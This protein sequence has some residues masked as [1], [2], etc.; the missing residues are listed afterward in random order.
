[1]LLSDQQTM[2]CTQSSYSDTY[3]GAAYA[4]LDSSTDSLTARQLD[5]PRQTS[6]DLDRPRRPGAWSQARQ[7]RQALDRNLTGTRQARQARPRQHL[8]STSTV[9]RQRLDS[10]STEPRQ[11]D[12]STARAQLCTV[13][14]R[15]AGRQACAEILTSWPARRPFR[16][17]RALFLPALS[18]AAR[19]AP[20][21]A[22]TSR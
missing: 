14:G 10:A 3:G 16:R 1:M 11:L 5:R 15:S 7:A 9:P 12:S 8:D 2:P 21:C 6:T 18:R 13:D 19:R 17:E 4:K 20:V 22:V